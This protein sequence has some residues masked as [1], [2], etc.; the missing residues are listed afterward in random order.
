MAENGTKILAGDWDNYVDELAKKIAEEKLKQNKKYLKVNPTEEARDK[1]ATEYARRIRQAYPFGGEV[2]V[3]KAHAAL[4]Q[5]GS[6]EL[7]WWLDGNKNYDPLRV[8]EKAKADK[9]LPLLQG[10]AEPGADWY[11]MGTVPLM[12]KA[13][14]L[15][16]DPSTKEGY[17]EFLKDVAKYQGQYDRGQ[18]VEE[19][20]NSPYYI[21]GSIAAPTATK[22]IEDAVANGTDL[23]KADAAKLALL[24]V[25]ANTVMWEAPGVNFMKANP[26]LQGIVNAGF[27]GAAEGA[28]QGL[29]YA[30]NGTDVDVAAPFA[31]MAAGATRPGMVGTAQQLASR[32][33]GKNARDFSRGVMKATRAGDP[34]VDER[35]TV[36][37]ALEQFNRNMENSYPYG[38]GP[39]TIRVQRTLDPAELAKA[40][41]AKNAQ[42]YANALDGLEYNTLDVDYRPRPGS[43]PLDVD[44]LMKKYDNM[45]PRTVTDFVD[46]VPVVVDPEKISVVQRPEALASDFINALNRRMGMAP[47]NPTRELPEVKGIVS[48]KVLSNLKTLFPAKMA[49]LEGRTAWSKAGTVTGTVLGDL[50]GRVEPIMRV[51]PL[52]AMRGQD[53]FKA[54]DYKNKSWYKKMDKSSRAILDAA[55]KAKQEEIAGDNLY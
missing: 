41:R 22:A 24:D 39:V 14:E 49:D 33:Q 1:Y 26:V 12:M 46:G 52:D 50:G 48:E 34:V 2:P 28:R 25:G 37:T 42:A 53:V 4:D 55:I 19:M 43:G 7:L 54:P 8:A 3:E 6:Q 51:N 18:I 32:F 11:T 45:Q 10:Q 47:V 15:G 29:G 31:A 35:N 36:K 44:D 16:Y 17:N 23:S 40:N 30:M 21:L 38:G 5:S 9:F 13:A 20:R 27:Q